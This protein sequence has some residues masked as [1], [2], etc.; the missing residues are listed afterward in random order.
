MHI[1]NLFWQDVRIDRLYKYL[2]CFSSVSTVDS[3]WIWRLPSVNFLYLTKFWVFTKFILMEFT[4]ALTAFQIVPSCWS[5][6]TGMFECR[7]RR[8]SKVVQISEGSYFLILNENTQKS[9][10]IYAFF[11]IIRQRSVYFSLCHVSILPTASTVWITQTC[12]QQCS[13]TWRDV[14]YQAG[15]LMSR[16]TT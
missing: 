1:L 6:L 7:G 5:H 3:E 10:A 2:H 13:D 12:L 9:D 16:F 4:Q 14:L 8:T 11:K 15:S